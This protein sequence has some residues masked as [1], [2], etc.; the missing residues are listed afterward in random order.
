[1]EED[2]V[3]DMTMI[4]AAEAVDFPSLE[5]EKVAARVDTGAKTSAIWASEAQL[6]RDQLHVIF[7]GKGAHHYTGEEV[8]FDHFEKVVVTTS[9]GE[10]DERYKVQLVVVMGGRRVRGAFTL[11]D[12]SKQ[13]YP[14]LIGRNI[15]LGKFIVNV[16]ERHEWL[17]REKSQPKISKNKSKAFRDK[18]H[19]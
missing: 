14:V 12:R 19:A 17:R 9:T 16:K 13:V 7:F 4:G 6:H 18:D 10:M 11:A 3:V 5:F 1:M 8:M 15:L 2:A